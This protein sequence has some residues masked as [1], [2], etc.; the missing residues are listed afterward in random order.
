[1]CGDCLDRA[2]PSEGF[3]QSQQSSECQAGNVPVF[4]VCARCRM[5]VSLLTITLAVAKIIDAVLKLYSS[6]T[7]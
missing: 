4:A 2:F 6:W 3:G 7:L 5:C 1:V